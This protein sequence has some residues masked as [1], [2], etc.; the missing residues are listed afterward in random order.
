MLTKPCS[1]PS[2]RLVVLVLIGFVLASLNT[3]VP[4]GQI[5]PLAPI[6]GIDAA[7]VTLLGV[8][9]PLGMGF[10][11]PFV[12][13]LLRR[14]G[15]D[16]LLF[17]ASVLAFVGAGIRP[18][19]IQSLVWGTVVV[20]AAIGVVNVLIPVF[21]RRRFMGSR[22][23]PVFGAYA[24]AMGLGS[25][26]AAAVVVPVAQA[27]GRWEYAVATALIPAL[28]AVVGSLMM[29]D[30]RVS[31][32]ADTAPASPAPSGGDGKVRVIG[33]W[34]AWSLTAF[35]GVQTLLFYSL[36]AWLPSILV[37][38]GASPEF[39]GTGQAILIVGI[40]AGGFFSPLL[41]A[42]RTSQ[43]PVIVL[44]VVFCATG[45][46]GIALTPELSS[47]LWVPLLGIGL[48]GGQ[49]LPA[50]LYAHRGASPAHTAALSAFAQTGGFLIAA[51]GP[52]LL[53]LAHATLDNWRIPLLALAVICLL[54][55]GLSW[56]A[57]SSTRQPARV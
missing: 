56:R 33:T 24:L 28:L 6:A 53:S 42:P 17:W 12:P 52:I 47:W 30:R 20:A 2:S 15:E 39:A 7:A 55:L 44:I 32:R 25:A 50:V 27:A 13:I 38:A 18:F 41:A 5:G 22:S 54:N 4:F 40:A 1:A 34:L 31:S 29:L 11:A 10:A 35:F 57:G 9:P 48:G 26:L 46:L 21:V 37:D 36:L 43:T 8:I 49:A 19:G 45:M 23:G 14:A 16:R 3:R 51:T